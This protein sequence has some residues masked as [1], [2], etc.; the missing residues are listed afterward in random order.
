[1]PE[2]MVVMVVF[3][4]VQPQQVPVEQEEDTR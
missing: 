4:P 1:V 3:S 2:G